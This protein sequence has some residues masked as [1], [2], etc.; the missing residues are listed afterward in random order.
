MSSTE[1]GQVIYYL[2]KHNEKI[3]KSDSQR[4]LVIYKIKMK[5]I[6][7]K[8]VK[9]HK[10]LIFDDINGIIIQINVNMNLHLKMSAHFSYLTTHLSAPSIGTTKT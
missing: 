7:N 10:H 6:I 2:I 5:S 4:K 3:F 8:F 9:E 1:D